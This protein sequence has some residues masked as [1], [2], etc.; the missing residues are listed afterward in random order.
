MEDDEENGKDRSS[1]LNSGTMVMVVVVVVAVVEAAEV[2][3][4]TDGSGNNNN[5][6]I[7]EEK[8]TMTSMYRYISLFTLHLSSF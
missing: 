5:C 8:K 1:P 4:N 6:S 7:S 2:F 3:D